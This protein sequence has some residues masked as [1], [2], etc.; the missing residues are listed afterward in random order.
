G[1]D[2]RGNGAQIVEP[3][4]VAAAQSRGL[5]LALEEG[6][7]DLPDA[8][9]LARQPRRLQRTHPLARQGLDRGVVVSPGGGRRGRRG[10][11]RRSTMTSAKRGGA[12][13]S[14]RSV[15]PT[16]STSI[17]TRAAA[18]T[19]SA[20]ARASAAESAGDDVRPTRSTARS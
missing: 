4:Q 2:R 18:F 12:A 3:A 14:G 16:S 5:E 7:R 11:L 8:I 6:D 9:E 13:P 19:R 17:P 20:I 10:F 1:L 15:A